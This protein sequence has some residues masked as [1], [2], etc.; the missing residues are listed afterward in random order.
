MTSGKF[1]RARR[2]FLASSYSLFGGK[3]TLVPRNFLF[4]GEIVGGQKE[5]G[6]KF[7]RVIRFCDKSLFVSW[8]GS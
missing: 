4:G 7:Y 1:F 2:K 3:I 5:K 8:D 6:M